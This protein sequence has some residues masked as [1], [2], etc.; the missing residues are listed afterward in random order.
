MIKVG[1]LHIEC[2]DLSMLEYIHRERTKVAEHFKDYKAPKAEVQKCPTCGSNNLKDGV[3]QHCGSKLIPPPTPDPFAPGGKISHM[4]ELAMAIDHQEDLRE[5]QLELARKS[6]TENQSTCAKCG[7]SVPSQAKFCPGCGNL[8]DR[9]H[10][11]CSVCGGSAQ[12]T[13]NFC[14]HCGS[15]L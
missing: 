5:T 15:S 6:A 1:L 4:V 10:K 8:I 3:C 9:S 13:A 14:P 12:S 7:I 2:L 11:N